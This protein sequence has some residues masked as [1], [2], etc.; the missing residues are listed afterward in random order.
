MDYTVDDATTIKK[1]KGSDQGIGLRQ[2]HDPPQY[3]GDAQILSGHE[4][5]KWARWTRRLM[6]V[7]YV[8]ARLKR[9]SEV[10]NPPN[11]SRLWHNSLGP[12]LRQRLPW[13]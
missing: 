12:V 6:R 8:V 5:H 3:N 2:R 1:V 7:H 11:R 4:V 10:R 9:G 13:R